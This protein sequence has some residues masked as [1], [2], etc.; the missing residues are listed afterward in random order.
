MAPSFKGVVALFS[1][2]GDRELSSAFWLES[3][4]IPMSMG[5]NQIHFH[6]C[7]TNCS[8]LVHMS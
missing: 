3:K 8:R 6:V 1:E 5:N 7:R 4:K 2:K